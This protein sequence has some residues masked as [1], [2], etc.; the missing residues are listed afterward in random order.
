MEYQKPRVYLSEMRKRELS[1]ETPYT[2]REN[3]EV[4]DRIAR[5]ESLPDYIHEYREKD[6]NGFA[7]YYY[8]EPGDD[9]KPLTEREIDEYFK[10][11]TLEHQHTVKT[12]VLI[13]AAVA[14]LQ[15]VGAIVT[16]AANLKLLSLFR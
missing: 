4:R 3:D 8:A 6:E 13:I 14:I 11:K 15:V 1:S 10:F 16:I 7:R 9:N 12:A 2:D 5:G